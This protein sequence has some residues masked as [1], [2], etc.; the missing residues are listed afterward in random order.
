MDGDNAGGAVAVDEL[1]DGAGFGFGKGGVAEFL[2]VAAVVGGEV[3]VEV[4][5]V[6]IETAIMSD[7]I[8]IGDRDN[9]KLSPGEKM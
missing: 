4:D 1:M 2:V 6:A 3:A 5:A 8:G 7:A 9:Y